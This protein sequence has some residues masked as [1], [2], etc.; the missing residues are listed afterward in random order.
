MTWMTPLLADV[1][2]DDVGVVDHDLPSATLKVTGSPWTVSAAVSLG[3][4]GGHHLA[5]DHVVEQDVLE[6]GGSFSSAS[7]VP[8]GSFEGLVGGGEDGERTFAL[9]RVDQAGGLHGGTRVV[10][11]PAATAVSTM[12]FA[13]GSGAWVARQAQRW[14]GAAERSAPASQGRRR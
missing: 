7:T 14:A 11:L 2:G 1:G 3:Q 13:I 10:K 9:E 4:V 6:L 8:A 12:S 5:G